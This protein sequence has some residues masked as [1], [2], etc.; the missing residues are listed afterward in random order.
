VLSALVAASTLALFNS[1]AWAKACTDTRNDGAAFGNWDPSAMTTVKNATASTTIRVEIFRGGDSKQEKYLEPGEDTNY[2]A[3]LG[4]QAN[5]G[6]IR[7]QL[8]PEGGSIAPECKYIVEESKA[9]SY[10]D[11]RLPDGVNAVCPDARDVSI[12]CQLDFHKQ[13]YRWHTVF[14]VGDR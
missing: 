3:S 14:T 2:T 12:D 9:G 6:T 11:W 1:G 5:K 8:Y 4:G 10:L 13:K 7:V